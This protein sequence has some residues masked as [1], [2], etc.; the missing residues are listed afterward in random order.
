MKIINDEKPEYLAIVFD[1]KEP[2]FRH[3]MYP[4]YKST[5]AKMPDDLVEQ[6][7]RIYQAVEALNIARFEMAGYEADDIIGTIAR[8]GERKGLN[9]WCVTGDKDYFQL[10]SERLRIYYPGRGSDSAIDM[11]PEEVKKKFGVPPELVRDK[12][13]LMGDSSDNVPGVPGI[14]PKTADRLL[15]QFGT[16]DAIL[17]RH[18]EI[19]A[20]GV[21]KKI[22][23][24]IDKA[25][26]SHELVTIVTDVPIEFDLETLRRQEINYEAAKNLFL[27]LEL[28]NILKQLVPGVTIDTPKPKA[29]MQAE[30][31]AI[32]N[33]AEL[34][35]LVTKLSEIKEIAVDTETTSLN[36]QGN[37]AAQK[38]AY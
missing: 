12:L 16:L 32:S 29:T 3:E 25:R 33:L 11:G 28:H 26:L 18:K 20:T 8:A 1:T 21:R 37:A 13:A 36:A 10:V 30:Y 24:N 5:R 22:A 9:V 34:K 2:T 27:E 31:Q 23:G 19:A 14:G 6:L 15:E 4:E 38:A 17:K 7:P 35:D